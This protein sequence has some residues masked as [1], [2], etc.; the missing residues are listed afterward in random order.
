MAF[1][2]DL[3]VLNGE[4]RDRITF[5]FDQEPGNK[6]LDIAA[7][8]AGRSAGTHFYCCG[9]IGM[10]RAFEDAT[11]TLPSEVVHVEYFSSDTPKAQGGFEVVLSRTKKNIW[12]KPDQTILGALTENGLTVSSSCLEGVCGTC[13][14]VVLEGVPDHRDHVLSARER[15]SNKKMMICCSGSIGERLVLDL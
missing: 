7:V 14:T 11:R 4:Q 6:M 13:E 15:A 5:T 10:L 9:P 12:V 8:T 2:G 1:R 3:A